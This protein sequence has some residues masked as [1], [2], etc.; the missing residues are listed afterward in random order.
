MF[1][2]VRCGKPIFTMSIGSTGSSNYNYTNKVK[3][4][5]SLT[6]YKKINWELESSGE[7]NS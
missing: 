3:W 5:I 6:L 4:N 7:R 2:E 1:D